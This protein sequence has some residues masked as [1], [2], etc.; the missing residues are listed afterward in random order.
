[1]I[2]FS[3]S[4]FW[5][6]I[7]GVLF[8]SVHSIEL[9]NRV[10]ASLG[11]GAWTQVDGKNL[12][13]LENRSWAWQRAQVQRWPTAHWELFTGTGQDT[14]GKDGPLCSAL[15]SSH[16]YTPSYGIPEAEEGR[17]ALKLAKVCDTFP[18]R[19]VWG[20]R[21]VQLGEKALDGN[22]C[23]LLVPLYSLSTR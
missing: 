5:E 10:S 19:R 6:V 8:Q 16:L 23:S 4:V 11:K 14:E 20:T 15:L 18:V 13:A 3:F 21:L 12:E 9:H 17:T 7:P 1:M 2:L 22:K